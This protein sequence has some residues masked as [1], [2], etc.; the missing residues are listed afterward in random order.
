MKA[1]DLGALKYGSQNWYYEVAK[2]LRELSVVEYATELGGEIVMETCD[3]MPKDYERL[4]NASYDIKM[5]YQRIY[6]LKYPKRKSIIQSEA[7]VKFLKL[8]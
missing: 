5:Q 3:V 8:D 1:G 2:R 6:D 7:F 4:K